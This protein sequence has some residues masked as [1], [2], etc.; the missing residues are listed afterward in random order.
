MFRCVVCGREGEIHHIFSRGAWGKKALVEANEI[1]LCRIHHSLCHQIGA[2]RFAERYCLEARYE[3]AR[4]A[5]QGGEDGTG[6]IPR[7][8]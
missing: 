8:D 3:K 7:S 2:W 4:E 6:T 1:P 5:V